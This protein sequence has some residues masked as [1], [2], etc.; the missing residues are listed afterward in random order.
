MTHPL[1]T[2]SPARTANGALTNATSGSKVLDFF[3]ICAASRGKDITGMFNAALSENRELTLRAL[4]WLRDVRGGAGEREQ[5]R[6]L[7]ASLPVADQL[8]LY[9]VVPEVGRWD[10]LL[11]AVDLLQVRSFILFA[12]MEQGNGLAAKWMPRQ[13]AV[14][15]KLRKTA[16]LSA[17]D[18]RKLLVGLSNTVEQKMSAGK[19]D[20]INFAHVPSCASNLYRKAFGKHEAERYQEYLTAVE[21]GEAKINAAAIYPHD[22]VKSAMQG[23]ASRTAELQWKALPNYIGD[24]QSTF[25]PVVDVSGSMESAG[26]INHAVSLGVY[27]AE[28]NNSVFKDHIISFS[29]TPNLHHIGTGSLADKVRAVRKSGEDMST[30]IQGVFTTLLARAK[31][32]KLSQADMPT[33]L[34]IL[35]DMEFNSAGGWAD[36]EARFSYRRNDGGSE[37]TNYQAIV[38]KYRA[39]GYEV[40]VLV[41]WNLC[42]R[43]GNSPV[44]TDDF[45]TVMVSGFSPAIMKTVLSAKVVSPYDV[46]V[47]T[48]MNPRYD[49]GK[50]E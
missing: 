10:D 11:T 8:R 15:S 17:K 45:G 40:P 24:N 3:S 38:Q 23:T 48:L 37:K 20:E 2:T 9:S 21:K 32:L 47:E 18:W 22:I 26:V 19:W 25:L 41:F 14:A 30:N 50:A 43:G 7:F 16:D 5:F 13:G 33:H 44:T 1:F 6:K 31:Q 4:L 28:R 46:M 42:G 27:L 39:A 49:L 29:G 34:V 12:L 35:S 36:P